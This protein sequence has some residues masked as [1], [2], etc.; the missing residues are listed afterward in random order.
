MSFF[1]C[2][3]GS[4]NYNLDELDESSQI[5]PKKQSINDKNE[6]YPNN[7]L[8]F[9]YG[10]NSYG[11]V[12]DLNKLIDKSNT[13]LKVKQ[14][15]FGENHTL[16]LIETLDD[17]KINETFLFGCGSNSN[18]QLG[19]EYIPN[20]K[21]EYENFEEINL[22]DYINQ[23]LFFW[24]KIKFIID[25]ICV[26]ND[27]S[28]VFVKYPNSENSTLY[29]FEL[30]RNDR[31]SK[32]NEKKRTITKEKYD[33][34]SFGNILKIKAFNNKIIIFTSFNFLLLKGVNFDMEYYKDYRIIY[35]IKE[36]I[37][38]VSLGINSCL[39]LTDTHH[40]LCFGHNEYNEFG[41]T[42]F[43][44]NLMI[45]GKYFINDFFEKKGLKVKKMR[46]GA[47]HTLILLDN[48][49]LYAFGDNC[50]RQCIGFENFV[51]EPKK[52]ELTENCKII[53]IECGFNHSIAKSD[54][55]KIYA[56]GDSAYGKLGYKENR[57]DIPFPTEISELK[58]R[59][60][61]KIF[62]GPYQSA[63]FSSGGIL[64]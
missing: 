51:Y 35:T 5:L 49:E 41:I 62:A 44:E 9:S 3:V 6:L 27:F 40:I 21:N 64:Q 26:G 57:I 29:R 59:N 42:D 39:L 8:L 45:K 7:N 32:K 31:F 56:W 15:C 61:I 14:M 47:R 20:N 16:M 11:N 4:I 52:I 60:V 18:G 12:I 33:S 43:K 1:S 50:D 48:G 19:L 2:C 37:K 13:T 36:K 55:G 30:L 23:G 17:D 46:S 34:L 38:E 24:N 63:F 10:Y 58:V 54:K 53:D 25:S 28:L 22:S